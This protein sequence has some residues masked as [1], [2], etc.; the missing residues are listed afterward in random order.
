[1]HLSL[2]R[3]LSTLLYA[4][5]AYRYILETAGLLSLNSNLSHSFHEVA[6]LCITSPNLLGV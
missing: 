2:K 1:M 5:M 4:G 6:Y 3:L